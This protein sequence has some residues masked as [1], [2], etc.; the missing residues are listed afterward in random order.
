[1]QARVAAEA[2]SFD[3][4]K[5]GWRCRKPKIGRAN[6]A[7]LVAKARLN[8]LTAVRSERTF[9]FQGDLTGRSRA[10]TPT[11]WRHR[12]WSNIRRFDD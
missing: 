10:S 9:P 5:A 7:L 1:M 3:S 4:L 8:T 2:T 12:P 11:D 6:N